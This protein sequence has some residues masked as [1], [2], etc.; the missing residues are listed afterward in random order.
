V[1]D[2]LFDPSSAGDDPESDL[3]TPV[4]DRTV[5]T[6]VL[7]PDQIAAIV[8]N[9]TRALRGGSALDQARGSP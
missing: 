3:I 7:T 1:S 5:V 2:S 6:P 8:F 4:A 9:E